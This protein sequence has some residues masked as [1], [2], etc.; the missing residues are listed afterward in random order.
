MTRDDSLRRWYLFDYGKVI[1]AAPTEQD[2]EVLA[3][4]TG[5]QGLADPASTYWQHR[6]AYDAGTL[7]P[8]EYW[9]LV[10]RGRVS[11]VRAAWLDILDAHQWS[12][13]NL[14]TLDTLED[15]DA[16]GERL[17]L[18]SNMPAAMVLHHAGAPW[19]RFFRHRFFS[20]SLGL[21]KPSPAVFDHVLTELAV[22]PHL[23]TFIDDAPANIA[24]ARS[25][26]F[27]A[28]LFDPAADLSRE[29]ATA[30]FQHRRGVTAP[31]S[32][33]GACAPS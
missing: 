28:R 19:T 18:L 14:D 16:R 24:A 9:S 5:A 23:I 32:A 2:W 21:V 27:D 1:S 6:H 30:G 33:R 25:L 22:E 17:A 31:A 15:L 29:L 20:S 12:H 11:Q 7:T 13:P 3:E 4:A 10:C 26:G 8:D